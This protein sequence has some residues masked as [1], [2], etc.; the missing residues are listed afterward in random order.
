M[1]FHSN[2]TTPTGSTH[3]VESSKWLFSKTG[4]ARLTEVWQINTETVISAIPAYNSPHPTI[5]NIYVSQEV[6]VEDGD[7]GIS[8]ATVIYE[9]FAGNGSGGDITT[10]EPVYEWTGAM[11]T[12]PIEAHPDFDEAVTAVRA[13]GKEPMD[14]MGRFV[15]FPEGSFFLGRTISGVTSYPNSGGTWT[16]RWIQTARPVAMSGV[17]FVGTPPGD[18]PEFPG[19]PGGIGYR[20]W[21][22]GPLV[23]REAGGVFE[24]SQSWILS[25]PGGHS[26]FVV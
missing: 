17:G 26:S 23:Y 11:E 13:L 1:S 5:P 24:C 21:L 22:T 10:V 9:G 15:A 3:I 18:P 14:D 4:L 19:S 2:G 8:I 12:V 25:G 20:D 6:S 16:K 7:C